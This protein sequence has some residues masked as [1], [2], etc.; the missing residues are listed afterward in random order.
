MT[1]GV[2]SEDRERGLLEIAEPIGVVVALLPITNPTSTALSKAIIAAK[3][4][5]AVILRPAARAARCAQRAVEIMQAA[6]QAAGMPADALQVLTDP[7]RAASQHLF[8]HPDVDLIWTTGGAKAVEAAAKAGKPCIGVGAGNAPAYVH[9]SADLRAAVVDI[10]I[11]KTF[12]A[13]VICAAETLVIDA[14]STTS[15][16]RSSSGWV[17]GR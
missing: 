5:N 1:V 3:T 10:L 13:S 15:S 12:D 14:P 7:T 2:M 4:R 17:R 11:S 16:W 9:R 8:A 6:G